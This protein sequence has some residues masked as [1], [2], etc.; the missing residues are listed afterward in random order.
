MKMPVVQFIAKTDQGYYYQTMPPHPEPLEER[1]VK[2]KKK[3]EE[4]YP[5]IQSYLERKVNEFFM[6]FY[7]TLSERSAKDL[8]LNEALQYIEELQDFYMKAWE[9]HFEISIPRTYLAIELEEAYAKVTGAERPDEVYDLLKGIMN[10]SLETDR[11]LWLLAEQVKTSALLRAALTTSGNPM[12]TLEQTA[13]G[14]EFMKELRDFLNIYGHRTAMTHEFMEET[15]F[16]NP[17][18]ALSVITNYVRKEYDFDKEFK[19]VVAE[20]HAKV[21]ELF[22]RLPEG[23]MTNR[24][25]EIYGWA[26]SCWGADE[27]HHFYIDA[28]MAA[29]SR[30]FLKNVGRTLVQHR[31]LAGEEDIFFLYLDDLLEVLQEPKA[32]HE[33]ARENQN[34]LKEYQGKQPNPFFGTPSDELRNPVIERIFGLPQ[35]LVEEQAKSFRGYAASSGM[36]TGRVKI[37]TGQEDFHKLNKGDILVCKTATPPWTVLFSVAGALITDAGGILSHASIVAR[38]YKLPSVVGTKVATSILKDGDE[39]TVDGTNGVVYLA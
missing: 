22:E 14:R 26:L 28:M 37:I 6:P 35:D 10:M 12:K 30:Y 31:I 2:H 7:N 1:M 9:Y 16:E 24:F 39:V 18:Y 23:E 4:Y 32:L 3:M 27:D 38:E 5:Q 20:R 11:G 25:K 21:Y 8:S 17:S 19:Q 13:E 33:V 15:W 29:K 34:R 36:Y